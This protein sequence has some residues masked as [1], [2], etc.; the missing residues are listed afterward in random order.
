LTLTATTIHKL[1]GVRA[2]GDGWKFSFDED[3]PLP[4]KF[5]VVDET[6][7][8]DTSLAASLLRACGP[9]THLLL[10]GDVNQLPPVGH[11]APLRDLLDGGVPTAR[12]REIRRNSGLIVETCARI[13]D[14]HPL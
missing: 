4:Y 2:G 11:G 13:K 10:V 8:L 5:V 1:L 12:L 9:G 3:S 14:G 6:S 7:M